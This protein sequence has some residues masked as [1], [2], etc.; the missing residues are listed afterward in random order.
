[1]PEGLTPDDRTIR[2]ESKT[3][4]HAILKSRRI[5]KEDE[6]DQEEWDKEEAV[7]KEGGQKNKEEE[8]DPS[9]AGKCQEEYRNEDTQEEEGSESP[10]AVLGKEDEVEAS[11]N[12]Q[13]KEVNTEYVRVTKGAEN[14]KN[15]NVFIL[16]SDMKNEL[17]ETKEHREN[18]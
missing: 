2:V 12:D 14:T 1:M 16:E 3:F 8:G 15:R 7:A 17:V 13:S 5:G 9:N 18:T 4:V 10:P 11:K 6:G